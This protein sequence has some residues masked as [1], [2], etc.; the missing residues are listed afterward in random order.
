MNLRDGSRRIFVRLEGDHGVAPPVTLA[1]HTT[2]FNAAIVGTEV[3]ESFSDLVSRVRTFARSGKSDS[4]NPN[5][6]ASSLCCKLLFSV[7]L[8]LRA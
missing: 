5:P 4:T 6:F 2:L 3:F 1:I 8:V 7:T